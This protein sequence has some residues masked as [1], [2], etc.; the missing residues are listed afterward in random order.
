MA[1]EALFILICFIRRSTHQVTEKSSRRMV[2]R[3]TSAPSVTETHK[4]QHSRAQSSQ[5]GCGLF[6]VV[7]SKMQIIVLLASHSSEPAS[8]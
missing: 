7:V 4:A 1:D 3:N 8:W 2:M 5:V 6:I